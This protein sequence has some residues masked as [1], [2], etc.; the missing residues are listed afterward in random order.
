MSVPKPL[1]DLAER[2]RHP[3]VTQIGVTLTPDGRWALLV[4]VKAGTSLPIK[5]LERAA[6]PYG[7]V[8]EEEPA[9]LPIARPAYPARGE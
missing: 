6:R 5:A 2:L 7:L 4:Q 1:A 8:Y 9:T 3:A